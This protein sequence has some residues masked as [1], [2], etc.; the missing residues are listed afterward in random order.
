M[1][2]SPSQGGKRMWPSL[3]TAVLLYD[4]ANIGLILGLILGVVSTVLVVWMGN[5]KEEHLN[6]ELADSRERTAS[7]EKQS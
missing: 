3:K 2:D 4:L 1:A 5:V 7:L 6:R